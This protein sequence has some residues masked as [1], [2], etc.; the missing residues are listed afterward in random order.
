MKVFSRVLVTGGAG[1]IGSHLV[2]ALVASGAEVTVLDNLST[3]HRRNLDSVGKSVTLVEGDI[4]DRALLDQLTRSCD[5]VFHHAAIVSVTQSVSDPALSC[6]VND[7]GTVRVLDACRKNGV[8]RVVMA[9]SSAVYGDGPILP[10]TET[11]PACPLS[12][13]AVQKLSGEHYAAVFGRLY[14][15]ETVCLRYFNVYGPRQTPSSPY[16]GVISLFVS[17]AVSGRPPT[18]YGDGSQTRDFVHVGDVVR[19]NLLAAT[20]KAAAGRVFN[21]GTG[22]STRIRDLW[23]TIQELSLT[24]TAPVFAPPRAGD[25]QDSCSD[26]SAITQCLDFTPKVTIHQGLSDTLAWYHHG[27]GKIPGYRAQ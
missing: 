23:D 8:G 4:R 7:L 2:E 6:D 16:S 3:G 17:N 25:I 18:I 20:Q 12:P 10:K 21:V 1:F 14:G 24:K 22:V 19:A 9:S 5:V 26:I 27:N 11:M 13:Y 15:L